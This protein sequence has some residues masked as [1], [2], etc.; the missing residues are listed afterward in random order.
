[1][2]REKA[3]EAMEK[4]LPVRLRRGKEIYVGHL[5]GRSAR[6]DGRF[7]FSGES[8][9]GKPFLY[10]GHPSEFSLAPKEG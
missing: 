9:Q 1:M 5:I 2:N 3:K 6:R 10:D 8:E 7:T 4:G